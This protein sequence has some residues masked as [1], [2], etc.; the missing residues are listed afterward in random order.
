MKR[1][2]RD[3]KLE[4]DLRVWATMLADIKELQTPP[5]TPPI[6]TPPQDRQ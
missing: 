3:E 4:D 6:L 5:I 1:V 2:R